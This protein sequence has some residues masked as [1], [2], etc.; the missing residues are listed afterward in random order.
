M[1]TR[2]LL[3][4]AL[5]SASLLTACDRSAPAT[6]PDSNAG[7]NETAAEPSGDTA[8]AANDD[9]LQREFDAIATRPMP[10]FSGATGPK[11]TIAADGTF[12]IGGESVAVDAAQ[13]AR[14][15]AYRGHLVTMAQAGIEMDSRFMDAFAEKIDAKIDAFFDSKAEQD[16]NRDAN[17]RAEKARIQRAG[18][19]ICETLPALLREQQALVAAVPRFAPYAHF[20]QAD[21]E[22][23][24]DGVVFDRSTGDKIGKTIAAAI[25]NP[26]RGGVI[27]GFMAAQEPPAANAEPTTESGAETNAEPTKPAAQ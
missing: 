21:V 27:A 8:E 10:L 12:A 2:L 11:A 26:F 22:A 1:R 13:R 3:T 5:L 4:A 7:A 24:R 17:K 15:V 23:C 20:A 14:L 19:R 6:A 9:E 16:P 18:R 25:E